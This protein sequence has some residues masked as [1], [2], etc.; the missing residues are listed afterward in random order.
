[1]SLQPAARREPSTTRGL[2]DRVQ[3]GLRVLVGAM[4]IAIGVSAWTVRSPTG[5]RIAG[6]LLVGLGLGVALG[7]VLRDRARAPEITVVARDALPATAVVRTGTT[8]AVG[9][10][11]VGVAA[12]ACAAWTATA[13]GS[14]QAGWALVLAAATIWIG[15]IVVL[16]AAGRYAAGGLWLT[17]TG[18]TYRW[19]GLQTTISWDGVGLVVDEPSRGYVA[20]R[21]RPGSNLQHDFRAGPWHGERLAAPDVAV[22]RVEGTTLSPGG[23]VRILE[24]YAHDAQARHELGTAASVATIH[25][26]NRD[27]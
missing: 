22:L 20:L 17:P 24:H 7:A 18:L 15:S 16:F 5:A 25:S 26:L 6:F 8:F 4:M 1:M 13:L 9:M 12:L 10:S 21:A 14:G 23:L 27:R 11:M 3:V 2:K 19:R